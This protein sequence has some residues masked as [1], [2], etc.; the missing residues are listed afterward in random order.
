MDTVSSNNHRTALA[1]SELEYNESHESKSVIIRMQLDIL[2]SKL[3]NLENQ[4]LYALIWTTTPWSLLANQAIS[5]SNDIV[6]CVV[7]DN[8]KNLY[9]IAQECLTNIEQKLSSLKLI[10]I[11]KGNI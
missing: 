9:I 3:K 4:P 7:E 11:I 1:E 10:T 5:F 6:Y 8:S 2:P